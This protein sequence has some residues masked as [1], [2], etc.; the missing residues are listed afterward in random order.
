M[1]ET[2]FSKLQS[3]TEALK[4]KAPL[5]EYDIS[6]T[7]SQPKLEGSDLWEIFCR[8]FKAVN[9]KP[10]ASVAELAEFLIRIAEPAGGRGVGG[11]TLFEEFRFA[12]AFGRR[13]FAEDAIS[14]LRRERIAGRIAI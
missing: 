4:A 9:G 2:I 5:P 1:R 14:L 3:A 7:H 6:I 8:N 12:R 10:M 13:E 11:I